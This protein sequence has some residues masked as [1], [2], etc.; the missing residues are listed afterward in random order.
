MPS[1]N[2]I[3]TTVD[4]ERSFALAYADSKPERDAIRPEDLIRVNVDV[5][6]AVATVLGTLPEVTALRADVVKN[7][8]TFDIAH[9]DRLHTYAMALSHAFVQSK[10]S[11][12][13][14][15]KL[16]ELNVEA[17][18][19]RDTLHED[20]KALARRGLV[21]PEAF[22]TCKGLMGYKIVATDLQV[23]ATVARGNWGAIQGKCGITLD[24]LDRAEKVAAHM[25]RLVGLREQAPEAVAAAAEDRDRAFTLFMRSYDQVRRAVLF[26]RWDEGDHDKIAPS[27]YAGRR[28]T[29]IDRQQD[30]PAPV[31]AGPAPFAPFAPTAPPAPPV[32]PPTPGVPAG[33]PFVS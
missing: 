27:L 13:E 2:L 31:V 29:G 3:P 18:A 4:E 12:S 23:L 10:S 32:T 9:L 11:T 28:R 7:L 30:Q 26:L 24:E 8:P 14:V 19:L 15:D 1:E 22:R 16:Q 5:P 33:G 25:L 17:T 20:V 6:S 21:N